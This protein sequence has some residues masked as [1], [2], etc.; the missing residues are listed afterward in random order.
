MVVWELYVRA[1]S[2]VT[3]PGLR[4]GPAAAAGGL[5]VR[6]AD[7]TAKRARNPLDERREPVTRLATLKRV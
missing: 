3:P 5:L 4:E 2:G 6:S 1:V 7:E